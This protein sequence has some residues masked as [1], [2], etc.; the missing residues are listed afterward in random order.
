MAMD[1]PTPSPSARPPIWLPALLT[2]LLTY[3]AHFPAGQGWL[4][5]FALVPLLTLVRHPGPRWQLYLAAYLGGVLFY[6]AAIHWLTTTDGRMYF[7]W[8]FLVFYGALYPAVGLWLIRWLDRRA[9]WPL[10]LSVPCVWTALE[11]AKGNL[12]TGFPWYLFAHTQHD[13]GLL[14]QVAD[15][16]GAWLVSFLV[17][18]VN[19]LLAELWLA[20]SP[21]P[22]WSRGA[23]TVQ[24]VGVLLLLGAALG[25]GAYRLGE[26]TM[27]PG[28]RVALVQTNTKQ[29][30]RNEG[31]SKP[32]VVRDHI[33]EHVFRLTDRASEFR[34]D[35]IVWPETAI[36][37][38]FYHNP[39]NIPPAQ[40]VSFARGMFGIR[41]G[42]ATDA[43]VIHFLNRHF[44]ESN[45]IALTAAFRWKTSLLLGLNARVPDGTEIPRHNSAVFVDQAGLMAGLYNKIHCVPFGEYAPFRSLAGLMPFD[46][47]YMIHPGSERPRLELHDAEG[48][49]TRF[50]VLICYEDS[51]PNISR[52]Y[53]GSD[54]QPPADF[55]VNISNDGWFIGSAEH[56][57]HLAICRFRAVENRRAV[58]RAV[59]MGISAVVD[60]NGRVLRPAA[61][62]FPTGF[63][64]L[65]GGVPGL[66][67]LPWGTIGVEGWHPATLWEIGSDP[68]Q[69]QALPVSEWWRYEVVP[70][71]LVATVP[72][73]TRESLYV[74][75]GDWFP[76]TCA[77]VV[78]LG[79][80]VGLFFPARREVAHG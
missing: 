24:A 55:L 60:S 67:G 78:L 38:D 20:R 35:L 37:G 42:D 6:A 76:W 34:P 28:P 63:G 53:G 74:R 18:A 27:Q 26:Q 10:V 9:R 4:G 12:L 49:A 30:Y 43:E 44:A 16:G 68:T 66:G 39:A 48:R 80:L 23:L 5:W 8:A 57:E 72:L 61:R 50:G 64:L 19:G 54:G 70:G 62:P 52:P 40:L 33:E 32:G 1:D 73:D 36:G 41:P 69:W 21:R 56:A 79:F 65:A 59:N 13:F 14:I 77:S 31:Y 15:L 51:D 71:V 29:G 7:A 11:F 47:P 2:A 17:L 45:H 58:V 3:L 22:R 46:Y 75:W 25:Y